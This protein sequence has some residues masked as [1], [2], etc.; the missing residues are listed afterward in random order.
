MLDIFSILFTIYQTCKPWEPGKP[1][2]VE[3][4]GKPGKTLI[5]CQSG[6]IREKSGNLSGKSGN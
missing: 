5:F 2:E 3:K 1:V 4:D 6:K